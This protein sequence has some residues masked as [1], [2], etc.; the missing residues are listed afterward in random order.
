MTTLVGIDV[1]SRLISSGL[2]QL[3][4][5]RVPLV[6]GSAPPGEPKGESQASCLRISGVQVGE[7]AEA[8]TTSLGI[9]VGE[10]IVAL[11]SYLDTLEQV[12]PIELKVLDY[13]FSVGLPAGNICDLLKIDESEL[14]AALHKLNRHLR[15]N[16]VLG[17]GSDEDPFSHN[18]LLS[19]SERLRGELDNCLRHFAYSLRLSHDLDVKEIL[20]ITFGALNLRQ[21]TVTTTTGVELPL[22]PRSMEFLER[23]VEIKNE[24]AGVFPGKSEKVFEDA[25][26]L[27]G[28]LYDDESKRE[29]REG[30]NSF[31]SPD[32]R[33]EPVSRSVRRRATS[34][35]GRGAR[36][37]RTAEALR[38][39]DPLVASRG[40]RTAPVIAPP[41][42]P[43]VE[44]ESVKIEA[45][46]R[47]SNE[48]L[49]LS[50]GAQRFC[51]RIWKELEGIRRAMPNQRERGLPTEGEPLS[52]EG[53]NQSRVVLSNW[54]SSL[55]VGESSEEVRGA[56]M[57]LAMAEL[58]LNRWQEG[59]Q[60]DPT[61]FRQLV[62]LAEAVPSLSSAVYPT[63]K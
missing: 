7:L 33:V 45:A 61:L 63:E 43:A 41:K 21:Q 28:L 48:R 56:R 51:L 27:A 13:N 55:G 5:P 3:L 42:A 57:E 23:I 35:S 38:Q 31:V 54:L 46:A 22:T 26:L 20:E 44:V 59:N 52:H 24:L 17:F 29:K 50:A 25:M 16:G 36:E 60:M 39:K 32:S 4:V 10:A 19:V 1:N 18:S 30:A 12:N 53:V 37:I 62:K 11:R 58:R 2:D 15:E 40:I 49:A 9:D 8:I 14:K 34:G 47:G 6:A